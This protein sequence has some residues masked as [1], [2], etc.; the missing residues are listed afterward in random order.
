MKI[1]K[2]IP[3]ILLTILLT[4]CKKTQ[5][6][7]PIKENYLSSNIE[8][9]EIYDMEYNE[10]K[11]LPRGT[12]V[13]EL[14]KVETEEQNY[15]K[16]KLGEEEF[17]VKEENLNEKIVQEEELYVRTPC[18][19]YETEDGKILSQLNKG[20]K[21]EIIGYNKLDENGKVDMY[22]IKNSNEEGLVYEKYLTQNEEEAN[23]NYDNGYY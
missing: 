1:K 6:E 20:D 21:L 14:E 9:V 7:K 15:I 8:T 17:L 11:K 2:I 3:V 18:T 16:I 23:K 4:S 13:Q 19:L 12:K 5:I 10:I 22:K